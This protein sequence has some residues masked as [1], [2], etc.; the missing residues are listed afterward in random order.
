MCSL[1]SK[2]KLNFK[3]TNPLKYTINVKY[4]NMRG[5]LVAGRGS[6]DMAEV[7]QPQY[8]ITKLS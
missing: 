1:F 3:G 5:V 8:K 6:E 4:T 2:T 7:R